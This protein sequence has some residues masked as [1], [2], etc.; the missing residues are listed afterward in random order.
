[1]VSLSRDRWEFRPEHRERQIA[2]G[3]QEQAKI[4]GSTLGEQT[5]HIRGPE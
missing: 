2:Q 4:G 3:H 5:L 1:M